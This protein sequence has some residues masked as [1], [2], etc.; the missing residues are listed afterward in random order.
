MQKALELGLK[1][2]NPRLR[3]RER[4]LLKRQ[5]LRRRSSGNARSKKAT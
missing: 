2:L 4:R 3:R 1:V 5:R